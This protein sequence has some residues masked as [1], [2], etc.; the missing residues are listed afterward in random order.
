MNIE[1]LIVKPFDIDELLEC[2][3]KK[4]VN[5]HF[6]LY[7]SAYVKGNEEDFFNLSD[8]TEIIVEEEREQDNI[9]LFK[10]ILYNITIRSEGGLKRLDLSA[11]SYTCLMDQKKRVQIFQKMGQTYKEIV[12]QIAE[13]CG[14]NSI[15]YS[16]E[17]REK[18]CEM[19]V[20]YEETNWEFLIRLASHFN[21]VVI[22]DCINSYPCF[23]FGVTPRKRVEIENTISRH[24]LTLEYGMR[25][26]EYYFDSKDIFNLCNEIILNGRCYLIY[27]IETV[28]K[29]SEVVHYYQLR[30]IKDFYSQK[31]KNSL[32][33]GHSILG[34][35]TQV[36]E[37]KV[38]VQLN[39]EYDF[40]G[41][42]SIWFSYATV[43]SSP[44]GEGWYCMPE[45]GDMVRLYFPDSEETNAYVISAVHLGTVGNMRRKP[46]EKSIRTIYDKEIR[47]TSNKIILTNHKGSSVVLDDEKGIRII[48][49]KMISLSSKGGIH[50]ASKD[51]TH[52]EAGGGILLKQGN[53][54]LMVRNG[55]RQNGFDVRFR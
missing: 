18:K 28:L 24:I 25:V 39:C 15:I 34:K 44:E 38:K 21:T 36:N 52:L 37:E 17:T 1:K 10:G 2:K 7:I 41:E 8:E 23:Y 40:R 53:N 4:Q 46:E 9:V 3:I 55:I 51:K 43:Y 48:S 5:Q 26:E 14:R 22:A 13:Q 35:I 31:I 19:V 12:R 54:V 47:L 33:A 11:R 45:K 6:E 49:K 32:I 27:G 29:N 30:T 50:F 42:S 16:I 20:Q